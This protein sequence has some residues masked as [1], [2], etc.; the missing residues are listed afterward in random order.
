LSTGSN[1]LN[2]ASKLIRLVLEQFDKQRLST[3]EK[4][5]VDGLNWALDLIDE[6]K[7]PATNE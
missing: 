2:Q 7:T 1:D 6:I 5:Q 3:F 4:G